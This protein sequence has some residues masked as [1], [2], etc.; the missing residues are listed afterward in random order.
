MPAVLPYKIS[1]LVFLENSAGELLLMLRAKQPNLG[2][3]SP[4][5]G[6]LE[7]DTGE[8]PFDCAV[9]ETI[10]ETGFAVTATDLHLF[11]MIAEKAYQGETHWLMFLFRCKRP[12]ATLPPDIAEGR[13]AF[14][15][16]E[17]IQSLPIPET[18]KAA[19][20]P[21]YDKYRDGFVALKADCSRSPITVQVEQITPS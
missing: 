12:I 6:K 2:V 21:I 16:R 11:A 4:I 20:W 8:S 15:T 5:G 19:L 17:S 7:M 18:D 13:F 10:E 1:V 9:R 14:F 3:W